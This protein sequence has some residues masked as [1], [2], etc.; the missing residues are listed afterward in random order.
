MAMFRP[1]LL[2]M[3][4]ALVFSIGGSAKAGCSVELKQS[5]GKTFRAIEC[6][7]TQVAL[8]EAREFA[9]ESCASLE[10][11][12][13]DACYDAVFASFELRREAML[14]RTLKEGATLEAAAALY[15]YT[16]EELAQW[17]AA[18]E[19]TYDSYDPSEEV[20]QAVLEAEQAL[21]DV[22]TTLGLAP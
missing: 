9:A 7:E 16:E 4:P 3:V 5:G 20:P 10:G 12:F 13:V 14:R 2:V 8:D 19:P 11:Q 22:L 6:D 17:I 18:N 21:A 15:G 1:L